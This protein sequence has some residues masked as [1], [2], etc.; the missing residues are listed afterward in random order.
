MRS[1]YT[2]RVFPLPFVP[3][4]APWDPSP[5]ALYNTL[6]FGYTLCHAAR[7]KALSPILVRERE[8]MAN[9]DF[10]TLDEEGLEFTLVDDEGETQE[11]EALFTFDSED[12]DT[13]Y[14]AYTDGSTGDDGDINVYAAI[15]DPE[16][17]DADVAAGNPVRLQSI[18]SDEEWELVEDLMEEYNELEGAYD[19][20]DGAD[21]DV[22]DE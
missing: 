17:F 1:H 15:Y 4:T 16:T 14:I 3:A 19:G 5:D 8:T 22:D 10:T 12:G 7:G 20:S 9:D 11:V 18:T 6:A 13:S 21:D 2:E